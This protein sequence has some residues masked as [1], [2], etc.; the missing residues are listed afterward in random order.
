MALIPPVNQVAPHCFSSSLLPLTELQPIATVTRGSLCAMALVAVTMLVVRP[1]VSRYFNIE[2]TWTFSLSQ[3]G[4]CLRYVISH[5]SALATWA[6][7]MVGTVLLVV[8]GLHAHV[9]RTFGKPI[10]V[11]QG[12][13]QDYITPFAISGYAFLAAAYVYGL[14]RGNRSQGMSRFIFATGIL[15]A[16]AVTGISIFFLIGPD[17]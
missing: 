2:I 12:P 9:D 7:A 11:W 17:D 3:Y 10:V 15:F 4:S 13:L 14:H 8:V 5:A 1:L 6:F 16:L